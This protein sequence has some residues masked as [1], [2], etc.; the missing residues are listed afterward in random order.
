MILE[1]SCSNYK[2]IKNKVRFSLISNSDDFYENTL[3]YFD[4]YRI[5]KS[6]VIYGANGSGK[7]NFLKAVSFMKHLVSWS[8]QYQPGQEI[9]HSPHKLNEF[10]I[11]SEYQ[12]QFV[13]NGIRYAYGFSII[14]HAIEEEYLYYY[15][16]GRKVKI[17]ERMKMDIKRGN[18]YKNEFE[19]SM[20]VLKDN[21]LFLSCAANFSNLKEVEDAYLFFKEDIVLYDSDGNN[22]LEYSVKL[23]QENKEIKRK[24]LML[25]KELDTGIQDT[26]VKVKKVKLQSQDVPSKIPDVFR[27]ILTQEDMYTI[28]AKI[29]YEHFETDLLQEESSGIK[30]LFE[31]ICPIIDIIQQGKVLIC[32]ELEASLH[33]SIVQYIVKMFNN[34]KNRKCAQLIF[35][36]HDSS[37][38]ETTELFRRDQIWFTELNHERGTDLY[39]LIEI[40]NVRKNEN[41]KK[42][43][44]SGKY[45][46]IPML[47]REILDICSRD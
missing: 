23:L 12:I 42:G 30:K 17:F 14:N 10:D 44:I 34:E 37:L 29:S 36:T 46:A 28:D 6:A 25:L 40:K 32:D 7:S 16:N 27:D 18:Q 8:I 20:S 35:S 33:E 3:G 43:Y 4:K 15:P 13:K 45:G 26:H 11:P 22:W 19:A 21:R 5:L 41:L 24:F 38:L 9:V 1:F 31:M 2:S 47:N 39:S